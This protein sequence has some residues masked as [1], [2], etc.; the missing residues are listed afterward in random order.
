MS[1]ATSPNRTQPPLRGATFLLAYLQNMAFF[2][3]SLIA[4]LLWPKRN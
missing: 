1:Q 4:A 2:S 3:F